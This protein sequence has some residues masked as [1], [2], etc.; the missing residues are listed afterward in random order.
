M[1]SAVISGSTL[2]NNFI[3][4]KSEVMSRFNSAE[5]YDRENNE[6][7]NSFNTGMNKSQRVIKTK[8]SFNPIDAY[9]KTFF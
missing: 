4:N 7:I 3:Y 9:L 8:D 5:G 1:Y 6:P 2:G